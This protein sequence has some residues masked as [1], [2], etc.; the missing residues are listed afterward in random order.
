M[1]PTEMLSCYQPQGKV[2]FSQ[3]C[4][5]H[6]VHRGMMS[7]PVWSNVLSRGYYVTSC[8][9]PCPFQEGYCPRFVPGPLSHVLGGGG[10]VGVLVLAFWY[11]PSG[12]LAYLD[13]LCKKKKNTRSR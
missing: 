13:L 3:A 8:L 11:W 12:I 6:S 2:M 5:S 10:G 4:V 9:A 7:L 1:Y